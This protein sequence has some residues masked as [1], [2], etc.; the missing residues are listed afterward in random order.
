MALV[1]WVNSQLIANFSDF[2]LLCYICYLTTGLDKK[3]LLQLIFISKFQNGYILSRYP[4]K[5]TQTLRCSQSNASNR[6]GLQ[7]KQFFF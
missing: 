4:P 5:K 6:E 7:M 2:F 3:Y 1:P